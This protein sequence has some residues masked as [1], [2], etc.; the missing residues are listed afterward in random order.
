VLVHGLGGTSA[1]IWK[2][3]AR[4]LAGDFTVVTYDLRGTGGSG[5]P[6][7]PY[8]LADF[9]G[10]LRELVEELG[11][12]RPSLVGHSLGGT[13]VLA[14][15]GTYPDQVAAVV[16]VGGPV[17]LPEQGKQ[18]MRERAEIVEAD[19]V[20][21]VAETVA[22]NGMAP[23]FREAHPD[24]FRAYVDLLSANE[25]LT[26][27]ATCLVVAE[28]DATDLLGRIEAPVLL[29]AGELDAVAPR[30]AQERAA[31]AIARAERVEIPDCAHIVPWEKPERLRDEVMRFLRN[32][33]S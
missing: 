22:T 33:P 15:A 18:G 20:G 9:V 30:E 31:A 8:S 3:L 4:D 29:L 14:Y 2:H 23:S 24:E 7:G 11:L 1:A 27:A 26:Y 5:R 6:V 28:M 32:A 17:V 10:D 21:M 13:I 12:E 16:A 25:A 19:G